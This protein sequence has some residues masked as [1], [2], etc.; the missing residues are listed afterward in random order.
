[1]L[2]LIAIITEELLF[3]GI[4]TGSLLFWLQKEKVSINPR[5]MLTAAGLGSIAAILLHYYITKGNREWMVAGFNLASITLSI[6]FLMYLW[7]KSDRIKRYSAHFTYSLIFIILTRYGETLLFGPFRSYRIE[8]YLSTEIVLGIIFA[9][10]V[11]AAIFY[12]AFS[13]RRSMDYLSYSW[14]KYWTT[15][16]LFIF[17]LNEIMSLVQLTFLLGFLP[18]TKLAVKILAPWINT[19]NPNYLYIYFTLL[20]IQLIFSMVRQ[21][22]LNMISDVGKNLAEKRKIRA[23][24]LKYRK[25]IFSYSLMLILT[26]SIFTG[27]VILSAGGPPDVSDALPVTAASDGFIYLGIEEINDGKLHRYRYTNDDGEYVR[28]L[29]I[30]K[31]DNVYGVGFDYCQVCGETGYYQDDDNVVCIECNSLININ[32]IGFNGGCNPIPLPSQVVDG[33]LKIA[34]SDLQILMGRFSK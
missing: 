31:R 28:F 26:F 22:S 24:V 10:L 11:I 21:N 4:L 27:S 13:I 14:F 1:M 23:A 16:L 34:V 17:M 32:T 18:I 29:V 7:K 8:G 25:S 15:L 5:Y 33:K 30:E 20:V 3:P 6:I 2:E 9:Y 19:V 12:L